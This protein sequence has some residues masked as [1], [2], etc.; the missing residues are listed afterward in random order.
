MSNV[1]LIEKFLKELGDRM[2]QLK[3]TKMD[4]HQSL[5]FLKMN[6]RSVAIE[7]AANYKKELES[8]LLEVKNEI[9]FWQTSF[10][11]AKSDVVRKMAQI[12]LDKATDRRDKYLNDRG[13]YIC[14][15]SKSKW[16]QEGE[17][18]SKYFLNI[19]KA[20]SNQNEMVELKIRNGTTRDGEQIKSLVQSFYKNLYERRDTSY[21]KYDDF[22]LNMDKISS[23]NKHNILTPRNI[24]ELLPPSGRVRIQPPAWIGF[25]TLSYDLHG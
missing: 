8:E 4:P 1:I 14:D 20:K 7:I 23:E 17:K 25:C 6:I 3:E 16:Y 18:G 22:F 15:R 2:G 21:A 10:E 5:E 9:S 13:T 12:N 24:Q 19:V 11:C